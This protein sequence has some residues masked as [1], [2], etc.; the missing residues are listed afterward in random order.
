MMRTFEDKIL[1]ALACVQELG[2]K[3]RTSLVECVNDVHELVVPEAKDTVKKVLGDDSAGEIFANIARIDDIIKELDSK[4]VDFVTFLDDDYP[5][6]LFDIYER[7]QVLFVKGNKE[8]LH[9]DSIAVVGTRKPTR[10]GAK[11]ADEFAR[12]FA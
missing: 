1:L 11:I 2:L 6:R 3:K 4:Q 10:Y 9:K 5:E 7:P 12:E 8:L